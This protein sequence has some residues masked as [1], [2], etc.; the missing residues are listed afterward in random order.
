MLFFTVTGSFLLL[1]NNYKML[2]QSTSRH[3][4]VSQSSCLALT[5]WNNHGARILQLLLRHQTENKPGTRCR[6][7]LSARL[8][9]ILKSILLF[10]SPATRLDA[11]CSACYPLGI[12]VRAT[13]PMFPQLRQKRAA[14][15][16]NSS[17]LRSDGR[18]P[19]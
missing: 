6:R 18:K 8:L 15:E 10:S 12:Q 13:R 9:S 1:K 11:G 2:L 19:N 3:R 14:P 4:D 17:H 16:V 7:E 5:S